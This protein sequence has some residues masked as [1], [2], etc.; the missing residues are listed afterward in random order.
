MLI[1]Q[2]DQLAW[3]AV[4]SWWRFG[5]SG[6]EGNACAEPRLPRIAAGW[7]LPVMLQ[8]TEF[9]EAANGGQNVRVVELSG[10]VL[11]SRSAPPRLSAGV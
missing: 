4:K 11:P 1:A 7:F 5:H 10:N 6:N 9:G 8:E 3:A 2:D